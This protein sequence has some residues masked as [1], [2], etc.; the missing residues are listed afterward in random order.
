MKLISKGLAMLFAMLI[1]LSSCSQK[2]AANN[3][4]SRAEK[5]EGFILM[6]DG[7]TTDGWRGYNLDYFPSNW[8]IDDEAIHCQ[9]SGNNEAGAEDGGDILYDKKFSDFHLKLEW[10]ISEGGNSGMFYLNQELPQFDKMY[11]TSPEMQ[12]LDNENHPDAKMGIAGNRQAGSLYDLIPAV[13]QNAKPFGEWNQ[14]EIIVKDGSVSHIQNGE[15][16]LSYQ[17]WTEEWDEMVANSKFPDLNPDWHKVAKS[18]Y[19]GV[20]DHG[21]DVWYRNIRIKEL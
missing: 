9:A 7:K 1:V 8:I 4:L 11:Y 19:F 5:K 12:V 21:D 18:G 20:Q 13:P 6:F 10:R 2:E 3:T 16:V 14:V 17:L 15:E